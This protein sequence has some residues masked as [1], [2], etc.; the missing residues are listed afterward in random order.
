[1]SE[2]TSTRIERD[3]SVGNLRD[4]VESVVGASIISGELEP[5]TLVSVPSLAAQF[6]VSATPVREA[7][8]NLQKR[9]FVEPVRNKGFRVTEVSDRDMREI[10]MLR[11]WLETP[12]I[13][14]V[15]AVFPRERIREFRSLAEAVVSAVDDGDLTEYLRAD[16]Q[17]H[18]TLIK[19][20][21]NRRL[22]D[23][24]TTLRQQTR[25]K[26]LASMRGTPELR[27]AASEHHQ[28]LDLLLDGDT[29]GLAVLVHRHIAGSVTEH[30]AD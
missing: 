14:E 27:R 2:S 12:A 7:M 5:G 18:H 6:A 16:A 3:A 30:P 15:A 1:M 11:A 13:Q 24:L 20:L 9:G 21:D 8:V 29:Q 28:I 25:M 17:F 4:E 19:L 26:S 22:L 23:T 10:T